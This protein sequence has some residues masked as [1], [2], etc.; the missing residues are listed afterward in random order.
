MDEFEL[1]IIRAELSRSFI[2]I[3]S[4]SILHY[5]FFLYTWRHLFSEKI[6]NDCVKKFEDL[7]NEFKINKNQFEEI[8]SK[9]ESPDLHKN[10]RV[11]FTNVAMQIIDNSDDIYFRIRDIME[12]V[13]DKL[14]EDFKF[15]D[16]NK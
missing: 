15:K 3:K 14:N 8:I 7:A 16:G 11:V 13:F 4:S 10:D 9:L 6:D 12:E 2:Q 1:E 5:Q